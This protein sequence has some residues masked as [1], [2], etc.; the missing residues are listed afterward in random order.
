METSKKEIPICFPRLIAAKKLFVF[1]ESTSSIIAKPGVISS[2]TPLLTIV[3]VS[4]GSSSWSHMA[5]LNPAFTSLGRYVFNEWWGKPASSVSL[6][7]PAPLLVRII[8]SIF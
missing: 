4:L 7:L 1:G 5:T 3:L 2:V 8:P 6:E